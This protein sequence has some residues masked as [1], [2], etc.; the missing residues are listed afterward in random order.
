MRRKADAACTGHFSFMNR[1]LLCEYLPAGKR[2]SR[3]TVFASP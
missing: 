3:S 1:A 2:V